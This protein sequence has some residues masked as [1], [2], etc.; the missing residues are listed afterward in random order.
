MY[1]DTIT[2]FNRMPS[3]L[4]DMWY[5]TILR[6]VNLN[7]DRAVIVNSYGES[8]ADNAVLNVH[9]S[10]V[11]DVKYISGKKYVLPKEYRNLTNDELV[12]YITFTSGQDFDFFVYGSYDTGVVNDDDYINGF[13]D[14]MRDKYDKVY[15]ITSVADFSVIPHL[16]ITGK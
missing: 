15:A 9:Y 10:V 3:R 16:Q 13:Y 7:E 8:S 5:P 11:D 1:Q 2:V 4:G 14:Y 6:N 12:K